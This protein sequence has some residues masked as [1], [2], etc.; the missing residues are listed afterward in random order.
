[1]API[2]RGMFGV[3][4]LPWL[5]WRQ[6]CANLCFFGNVNDFYRVGEDE[7]IHAHHDGK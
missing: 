6:E 4:H 2:E 3:K 7:S 5:E 1:M